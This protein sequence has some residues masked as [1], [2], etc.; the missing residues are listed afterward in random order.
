M[1]GNLA[2]R[3]SRKVAHG[4]SGTRVSPR[5]ARDVIIF[6]L[7]QIQK[8][9]ALESGLAFCTVHNA[10]HA[11]IVQTEMFT[12]CLHTIAAAGISPGNPV[13]S[14]LTY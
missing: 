10:T 7:P 13:I 1:E 9:R 4:R 11:R 14:A 8:T 6:P 5:F 12:Y 3:A 2:S